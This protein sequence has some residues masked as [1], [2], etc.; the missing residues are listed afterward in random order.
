MNGR[1][2]LIAGLALIAVGLVGVVGLYPVLRP[3]RTGAMGTDGMMG[4]GGM[5]RLMQAMMGNLL[6]LGINPAAL[7]QPHSEGARL[8]Q[9]YCT[10]C[11]GLPGPGLQRPRGGPRSWR[12]WP[13]AS[14]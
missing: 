2:P 13:R 12:A 3:G 11:H 4:H 6:P 9:H 1:W 10:Q 14:A 8:M 7:P 5:K